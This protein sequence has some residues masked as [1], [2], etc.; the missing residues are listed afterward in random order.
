MPPALQAVY[1]QWTPETNDDDV[2]SS[3]LSTPAPREVVVY[4][5][6][7]V[8]VWNALSPA[9]RRKTIQSWFWKLSVTAQPLAIVLVHSYIYSRLRLPRFLVKYGTVVTFLLV[10]RSGVAARQKLAAMI[11]AEADELVGIM[12]PANNIFTRSKL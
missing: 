10:V 7:L 3:G 11:E 1:A 6:N 12:S 4:V 8:I 5:K 2:K 9:A